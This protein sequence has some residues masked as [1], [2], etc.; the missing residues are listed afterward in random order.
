MS[1]RKLLVFKHANRLGNMPAHALFERVTVTRK[2]SGTVAGPAR[3]FSDYD[4]Q[5]R[6][7]GLESVEILEKF[8]CGRNFVWECD[9]CCA[10]ECGCGNTGFRK[11]EL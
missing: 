1:S 4:V 8:C 10:G 6:R 5:V 11:A 3:A 9:S 2:G 7:D